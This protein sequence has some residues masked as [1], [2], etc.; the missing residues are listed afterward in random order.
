MQTS[1]LRVAVVGSGISALGAAWLLRR[2]HEVTVL[3]ARH[4]AG[5]HTHTVAV[6]IDRDGR[7][8]G[9]GV[10]AGARLDRT[11][12]DRAVGWLPVDTGFIVYNEPTYPNLTRLFAELDVPTT[13]SDM[14]FGLRDDALDYEY[15]GSLAGLVAAQPR[16]LLRADHWRLVRDVGRFFRLGNRLVDELATAPAHPG[17]DL[18]IGRFVAA[19]GLSDA[20][21]DRYLR[22]MAAAIWSTG[23]G[24]VDDVPIATLL[25]FFRNHG[26][27]GVRTH[28]PW[29]TVEGG[30]S[31]Y[32]D[33]LLAAIGH[34]RVHAGRTV[35]GIAR[36]GDGVTIRHGATPPGTDAGGPRLP[37][38]L[39]DT[40]TD[41][42]DAVVV[43]THADTALAMLTDADAREKELLGAWRT[44]A[45]HAL[46]H[47][48]ERHLPRSRHARASWCYLLDDGDDP[49]PQVSLSYRMNRLQPL[50]RLA[51]EAG[52]DRLACEHVVTLNPSTRPAGVVWEG[53]YRH[54][55][56]DAASVA[57]Q[58]HL[59]ELNGAR[60][61]WFAGAWQ[62][63]GFHEDG[64]WSAVRVARDLGVDWGTS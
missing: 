36:D 39:P 7:P 22:P 37:V 41:R 61:T 1:R 31:A 42:F 25:T 56:L 58:P 9:A 40:G 53:V 34:E 62:R 48:D 63:W 2:R 8:V 21:A 44:S 27:L 29:R 51:V 17:H 32:R 12:P 19:T 28:H 20:F 3:E 59:H 43:A 24:P 45:N 47:T 26:L 54:P 52:A 10:T 50:E 55:V 18:T 35:L 23:T 5:G 33:R 16:N 46:L 64:L 30:S 15:A 60:R 49:S 4:R 6:P 57:T 11:L 13:P 14:S 38:Q